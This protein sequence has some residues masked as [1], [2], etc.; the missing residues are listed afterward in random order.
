MVVRLIFQLDKC[1]FPANFRELF[2]QSIQINEITIL[3]EFQI[4]NK[5]QQV[6]KKRKMNYI[7]KMGRLSM[8]KNQHK[9]KGERVSR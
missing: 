9:T 8:R 7:D 3:T 5:F 2:N 1:C 4:A 6:K